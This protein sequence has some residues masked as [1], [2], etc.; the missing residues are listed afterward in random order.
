KKNLRIIE[1]EKKKAA[2]ERA[3]RHEFIKQTAAKISQTEVTISA[4]ANEEG[5]LYGSVGPRDISRALMAEGFTVHPD[6]V[7]M[8]EPLKRLD[9]VTV[10]IHLA[11]DIESEVKVWVVPEKTV[12]DLSEF[13]HSKD[14]D[15]DT[16]SIAA[17]ASNDDAGDAG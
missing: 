6:Q 1:E 9:T 11:E 8:E 4:A 12:G 3:R 2:Q 14:E 10:K 16:D 17:D 13:D 15:R 5:H 7:R